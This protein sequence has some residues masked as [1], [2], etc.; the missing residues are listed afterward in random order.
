MIAFVSYILVIRSDAD[1]MRIFISVFGKTLP[2]QLV[3]QI[4]CGIPWGVYQTVTTVYAAEVLPVNLRGY[5]T[6]WV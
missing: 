2:L 5:L 6:R 4:L 1:L 3:G